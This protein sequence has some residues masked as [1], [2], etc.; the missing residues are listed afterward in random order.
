[1]PGIESEIAQIVNDVKGPLQAPDKITVRG[2]IENLDAAVGAVAD[3]EAASRIE[4]EGVR[5]VEFTRA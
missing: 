3:E 2:E 1:M 5:S 4:G